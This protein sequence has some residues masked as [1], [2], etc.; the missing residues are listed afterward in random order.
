TGLWFK[1]RLAQLE[2]WTNRTGRSIISTLAAG[3]NLMGMDDLARRLRSGE[4]TS[5][6]DTFS[7]LDATQDIEKIQSRIPS[8]LKGEFAEITAPFDENLN[9]VFDETGRPRFFR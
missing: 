4:S 7:V 6:G 3:S 5:E 9:I 2:T 1:R 8:A